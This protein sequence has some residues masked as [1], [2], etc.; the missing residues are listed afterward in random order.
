MFLLFAKV[1]RQALKNFLGQ[2][3][4]STSTSCR[5][6]NETLQICAFFCHL[7]N[8]THIL[9]DIRLSKQFTTGE[10]ICAAVFTRNQLIRL[11]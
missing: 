5:V 11:E 8:H 3:R 10:G 4:A 7:A 1:F 2:P 9:L 6:D